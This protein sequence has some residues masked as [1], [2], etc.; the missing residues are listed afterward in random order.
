LLL[1]TVAAIQQGAMLVISD[2]AACEAATYF[3]SCRCECVGQGLNSSVV[4][5][6]WFDV[7]RSQAGQGNIYPSRDNSD[8]H[9]TRL[10][11]LGYPDIDLLSLVLWGKGK[12]DS[13]W[14]RRDQ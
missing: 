8:C 13:P 10:Q 12:L 14:P 2:L 4:L 6:A 9:G 1:A 7:D 11:S 3:L 5:H